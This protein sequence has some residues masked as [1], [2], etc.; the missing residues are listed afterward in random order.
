VFDGFAYGLVKLVQ[1]LIVESANSPRDMQHVDNQYD[2]NQDDVVKSDDD[3]Y[4]TTLDVGN[5]LKHGLNKAMN[6][7]H[8]YNNDVED[9]AKEYNKPHMVAEVKRDMK[10]VDPDHDDWSEATRPGKRE[11]V[12]FSTYNTLT[13]V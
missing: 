3:E 2:P 5:Q 9:L 6:T 1:S 4:D 13:N 10:I 12:Y 11:D 7:F 8:R